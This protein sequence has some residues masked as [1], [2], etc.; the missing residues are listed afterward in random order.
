MDKSAQKIAAL[1]LC[2]KGWL[3]DPSTM[4]WY[5]SIT[6]KGQ[7]KLIYFDINGWKVDLVTHQY[8]KANWIGAKDF[9]SA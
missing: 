1:K 7:A 3:C 6:E 9:Q 5:T 8:D 2:E 4:T